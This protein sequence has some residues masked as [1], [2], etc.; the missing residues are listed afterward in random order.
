MPVTIT[1]TAV[2]KKDYGANFE[3][4]Q[5]RDELEAELPEEFFLDDT[6]YDVSWRLEIAE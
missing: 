3:P 1:A 2:V 6:K 4:E 5:I